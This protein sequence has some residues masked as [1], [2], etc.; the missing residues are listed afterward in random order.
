M[1]YEYPYTESLTPQIALLLWFIY[2]NVQWK[3][4]Q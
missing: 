3:Y 1:Y 2:S 4:L